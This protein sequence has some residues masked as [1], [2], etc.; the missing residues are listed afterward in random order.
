MKSSFLILATANKIDSHKKTNL[1]SPDNH[2]HKLNFGRVFELLVWEEKMRTIVMFG[3]ATASV[4][5]RGC[6]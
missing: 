5:W 2:T 3:M 1:I 6:A 4:L